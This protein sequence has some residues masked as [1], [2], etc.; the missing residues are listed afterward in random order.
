MQQEFADLV[1]LT[2]LAAEGKRVAL[3][4]ILVQTK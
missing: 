1:G 4:D 2:D 3:E